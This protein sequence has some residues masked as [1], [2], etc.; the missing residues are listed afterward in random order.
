MLSW[1][2]CRW[3]EVEK[4]SS[5]IP[6]ACSP[7]SVLIQNALR[8]MVSFIPR[9]S[10]FAVSGTPARAQVADLIHVLKWAI[11][12]TQSYPSID[13]SLRTIRFLRIDAVLNI[14]RAWSRLIL[15]SFADQF[16]ALFQKYTIRCEVFASLEFW[17]YR[18]QC[19]TMKASVKH[20]LTIPQQT[21]YL[22]PVELGRVERQVSLGIGIHLLPKC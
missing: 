18:T 20:E 11:L 9:L 13:V 4:P 12:S 6:A 22:V 14:P 16:K 3:W 7:Y 15:P 17:S 10:S 8:E 19:R 21:R 1:T 2:K 5:Y